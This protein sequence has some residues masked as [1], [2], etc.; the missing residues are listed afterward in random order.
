MPVVPADVVELARR[1]LFRLVEQSGFV[2]AIAESVRRPRHHRHMSK[3]DPPA[4]HQ[5]HALRQLANPLP[6][7]DPV[8]GG[9]ARHVAVEADPVDRADIALLVA[10][11]GLGELSR[12]EREAQVDQISFLAQPDELLAQL[13]AGWW[14]NVLRRKHELIVQTDVRFVNTPAGKFHLPDAAH[15]PSSQLLP[16]CW[17]TMRSYRHQT[18]L[19]YTKLI[20]QTYVPFVNTPAGKFHLPDAAHTPSSQLLPTCWNTMRSYRHQ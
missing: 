17:N 11:V 1:V 9:I 18:C 15:T 4:H 5:V 14:T 7:R 2:E 20:V 13:R 3:P 16:T 19:L 12:D 6:N 8:G 10:L